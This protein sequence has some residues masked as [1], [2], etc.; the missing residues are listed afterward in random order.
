M[1]AEFEGFL[2]IEFLY[3]LEFINRIGKSHSEVLAVGVWRVSIFWN[4]VEYKHKGCYIAGIYEAY[5][6]YIIFVID[7]KNIF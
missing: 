4:L 6:E 2:D 5:C 3:E 1:F 7:C